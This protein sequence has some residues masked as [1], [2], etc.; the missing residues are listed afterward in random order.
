[1]LSWWLSR[2]YFK[3]KNC[4]YLF[5]TLQVTVTI[6]ALLCFWILSLDY[7]LSLIYLRRFKEKKFKLYRHRLTLMDWSYIG[8]HPWNSRLDMDVQ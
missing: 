6:D 5:W 1:M 8:S 2:I 7:H 4:K 3:E